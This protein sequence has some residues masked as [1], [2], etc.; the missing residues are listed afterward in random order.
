MRHFILVGVF[1]FAGCATIFK[2]TKEDVFLDGGPGA[3]EVYLNGEKIG[4]APVKIELKR[5]QEYKV[6]FR[7]DGY[8]SKTYQISSKI[9]L[10]W[11]VLDVIG[12]A[13]PL[14][15]DIA[16]GACYSLEP[17]SINSVL[18]KQQ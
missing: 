4:N 2:G 14:V 11:V 18:E 6:D 3:V 9:G 1:L 15:V 13:V 16:T 8:V 7:K 5:D 12:G 10:G 17:N